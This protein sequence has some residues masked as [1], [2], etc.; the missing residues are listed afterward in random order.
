MAKQR[1]ERSGEGIPTPPW[2]IA[3]PSLIWMKVHVSADEGEKRERVPTLVVRGDV[4][5]PAAPLT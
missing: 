5:A 1:S 3:A 4:V 2:E